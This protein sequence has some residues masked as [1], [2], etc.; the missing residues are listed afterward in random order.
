MKE[1]QTEE[2]IKKTAK[3]IF[4]KKG[5][6]H[7]TTQDIANEAGVNR[8]LIHYYFRSRELLFEVV[9]KDALFS[10][11]QRMLKVVVS[12]D[13]LKVK[14]EKFLDQF[15]DESLE[16]PYLETFIITEINRNPDVKI[17]NWTQN[18]AEDILLNFRAEL[19]LEMEKG[20]IPQMPPEQFMIN[21]MSLCS[22]P[23]VARPLIQMTFKM[24]DEQYEQFAK[25]RK[26]QIHK[27]IFG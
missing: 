19:I 27:M 13:C 10:M 8:A 18:I 1:S 4:F 7:A 3:D 12:E 17:P 24:S 23:I 26:K 5:N 2:L 21:L 15:I 6:I 14:I 11:S 20:T 9:L 25:D 16:Y 22:Y